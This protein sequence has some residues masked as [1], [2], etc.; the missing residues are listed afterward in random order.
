MVRRVFGFVSPLLEL[1]SIAAQFAKKAALVACRAK[2]LIGLIIKFSKS[3]LC[4]WSEVIVRRVFELIS[5]LL[6]LRSVAVYMFLVKLHLWATSQLHG[7]C[8]VFQECDF[9]EGSKYKLRVAKFALQRA[10]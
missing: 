3:L 8:G 6:E 1:R 5:P 9:S 4:T 7:A 2:Q 10:I